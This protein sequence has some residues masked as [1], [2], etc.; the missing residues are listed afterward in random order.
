MKLGKETFTLNLKDKSS[1]IGFS[2][3]SERYECFNCYIGTQDRP[4]ITVDKP[5]NEFCD[6]Q[7]CIC[8]CS[9]DFKLIEKDLNGKTEK[10]GQCS[11]VLNCKTIEQRDIISK[12][13]IKTYSGINIGFTTLGGGEEYWKNGFLFTNGVSGANGLK[14]Y[15]DELNTLIV[16]K[17]SNVIGICN[18]DMLVF[19]ND[20]LGFNNCKIL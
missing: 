17:R 3:N 9:E 19:N 11:A 8:L 16:E 4:A 10:F 2:K 15:S 12:V 5:K 13:T 7:A 18:K 14:L 20:K 6:G 1:I